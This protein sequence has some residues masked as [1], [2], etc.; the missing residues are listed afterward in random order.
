MNIPEHAAYNLT[1][2]CLLG[3][4]VVKGEF[5]SSIRRNW[6]R[7][8]SPG[9]GMVLWMQ[10][11][12][13]IHVEEAQVPID[14]LYL[15]EDCRVIE[16]VESFP[17]RCVSPSSPTAASVLAL[18]SGTIRSTRTSPG[19]ELVIGPSAKMGS[20][21][22]Q[23]PQEDAGAGATAAVLSDAEEH[24]D[25]FAARAPATGSRAGMQRE[26]NWRE[27]QGKGQA[28]TPDS[29]GS[30]QA[31]AKKRSWLE[32]LLHPDPRTEP[33][34][35]APGVRAAFWTV[36]SPQVYEIRNLNF[37]GMYAVTEERWYPG[38]MLRV[39]LSLPDG[40]QP[41]GQRSITLAS[42]VV[43]WGNDGVAF[44]FVL[45]DRVG[46]NHKGPVPSD[47]VSSHELRRFL[48]QVRAASR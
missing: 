17:T 34:E 4:E 16:A 1:R 35:P 21:L 43:R 32:R 36:G 15:D 42:K 46:K 8:L 23:L 9:S 25:R 26:D 29:E 30:A 12:R 11:F 19:D 41:E 45:L 6:L 24:P 14:L 39:T 47:T 5:L 28:A 31:P 37:T 20:L 7:K 38:T 10:P 18:S 27:E 3:G 44:E 48:K 2:R 13:G 22:E 40:E 33:R